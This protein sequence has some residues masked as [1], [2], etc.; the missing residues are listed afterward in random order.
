MEKKKNIED[1]VIE[2]VL[3]SLPEEKQSVIK[4]L[5]ISSE[6]QNELSLG[7]IPQNS[8]PKES[9][10]EDSILDTVEPISDLLTDQFDANK[11]KKENNVISLN[12]H[13]EDS[14][15]SSLNSLKNLNPVEVK[16]DH[17]NKLE[18]VKNELSSHFALNN[19][20]TNE[21]ENEMETETELEEEV[22]IEDEKTLFG[23][24]TEDSQLAKTSDFVKEELVSEK[25][26]ESSET[27]ENK[28]VVDRE[29]YEHLLN[30][31]NQL[32]SDFNHVQSQLKNQNPVSE[33][34]AYSDHSTLIKDLKN[35]IDIIRHENKS[36]IESK[37]ELIIDLKNKMH[38]KNVDLNRHK[39]SLK[40][41]N[42]KYTYNQDILDRILKAI[43]LIEQLINKK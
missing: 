36:L 8:P 28:E 33:N 30:Q 32:Q 38:S 39:E 42:E 25:V 6:E 31:F 34:Q 7:E 10:S 37:D 20:K 2:E 3:A 40:T 27:L 22:S 41:M 13:L 19:P 23:V 9:L 15:E 12:A 5:E 18:P 43:H 16:D 21:N 35:R 24:A 1:L 29:V 4:D 17:L 14:L 26:E 11:N